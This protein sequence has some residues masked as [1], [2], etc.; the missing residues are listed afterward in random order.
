MSNR[1]S[2]LEKLAILFQNVGDRATTFSELEKICQERLEPQRKA[3]L[4]V[5]S[6]VSSANALALRSSSQE[7][8]NLRCSRCNSISPHIVCI[9]GTKSKRL[10][11]W[12]HNRNYR[13]QRYTGSYKMAIEYILCTP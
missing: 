8:R 10:L 5:R 11:W 4:L 6:L 12:N 2:V 9:Y 1:T 3:M 7:E 13:N